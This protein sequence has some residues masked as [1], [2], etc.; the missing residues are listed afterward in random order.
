MNGL[1]KYIYDNHWTLG[2]IEKELETSDLSSGMN[3]IKWIDNPFRDRW[4]AD[5]FIL[6][7]TPSLIY[8]L[9]E[10]FYDP[11]SRGRISKL[12]INRS[13]YKVENVEVVLELPSHLSFPT[14][15]RGNAGVYIYPENSANGNLSLYYYDLESNKVTFEKIL[16]NEPL[17]DAVIVNF[18][19][20]PLI[21]STHIFHLRAI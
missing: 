5:P 6:E 14:I 18:W 1:R 20:E 15:K 16:C 19:D 12:T 10:E 21:F 7:V 13:T 4:F 17:T 11:I 9:V 3:N 8:I 2:L